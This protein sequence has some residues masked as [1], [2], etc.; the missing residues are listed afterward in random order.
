[1]MYPMTRSPTFQRLQH[2][3]QGE[4]ASSPT[5]SGS[6]SGDD[7]CTAQTLLDHWC[8][9]VSNAD[10]I[11]MSWGGHGGADFSGWVGSSPMVSMTDPSLLSRIDGSE[12]NYWET[13]VSQIQRSD[14]L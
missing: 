10:N 12:W 13:L 14:P 9:T 1:V 5:A 6:P 3:S 2:P 7:D 8:N 11:A 4:F